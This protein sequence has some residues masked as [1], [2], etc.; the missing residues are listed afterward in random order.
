MAAEPKPA[1][2]G[3]AAAAAEAANEM[4]FLDAEA[5][6]DASKYVRVFVRR[7]NPPSAGGGGESFSE[8]V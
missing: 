4:L 1:P 8:R 3:E 5:G 6:G 2:Q 7:F